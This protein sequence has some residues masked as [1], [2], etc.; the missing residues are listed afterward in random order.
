M[1][2]LTQTGL[3]QR[4]VEL[5]NGKSVAPM[6]HGPCYHRLYYIA[7]I[8]QALSHMIVNWPDSWPPERAKFRFSTPIQKTWENNGD[9]N[10]CIVTY[11]VKG[12]QK[13]VLNN[14]SM[15]LSFS[16]EI[17]MKLQVA[18]MMEQT[19]NTETA[20]LILIGVI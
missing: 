18:P 9:G 13:P 20:V 7:Y 3:S 15:G 17:L 2:W 19:Q 12:F 11:P 5:I 16:I 8:T 6:L 4:F 10:E 14:F 1:Q